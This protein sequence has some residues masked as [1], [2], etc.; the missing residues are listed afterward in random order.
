MKSSQAPAKKKNNLWLA[1]GVAA[2]LIFVVLGGYYL[3]KSTTGNYAEDVAA[4]FD[5]ALVAAGATKGCISGTNGRGLDSREPRYQAVYD[6]PLD[7]EKAKN[8]VYETAS[9]QGYSLKQAS[10]DQRGP[11][12]VADQFVDK[13]HYDSTSKTSTYRDLK[14]GNVE[15]SFVIDD[16]SSSYKCGNVPSNHTV[17]LVK[18]TLPSFK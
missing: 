10:V 14:D 16:A 2:A 3:V 13:W 18:V 12:A 4:P 8:L 1:I 5:K 17:V 15:L 6:V 7:Q 11:I 9:A